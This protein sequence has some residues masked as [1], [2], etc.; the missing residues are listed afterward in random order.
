MNLHH[1]KLPGIIVMG[2][3]V[4]ALGIIRILGQL[5]IPAIIMDDTPWNISRFS[6]FCSKF[7]FC[8]KENWSTQFEQW[9]QQ[10]EYAHWVVFPTHD[11]HV[12]FL[13]QNKNWLSQHFTVST[14]DWERVS[15]F[16]DKTKS[17]EMCK[18]LNIPMATTYCH[19]EP[20]DLDE[21]KITFPCIIKPSVM[22]QFYSQLKKK[23][24][25]CRNREELKAQYQLASSIIPKEEIIIQ[26][27]IQGDSASQFSVGVLAVNGEIM[28]Q[29]S[30]CRMRQHPIDFGNATTYAE[31]MVVPEI[32][33]YAKQI[34]AHTRFTGMCEIEFKK[35]QLDGEYK[36]LEVNPR[37]WKW[38]AIAVKAEVPF[39]EMF[40]QYLTGNKI[41]PQLEF[42]KA[43]FFHS[44]TDWP[45]R[46]KL[47][48]MG[49]DYAFQKVAPC[50]DAVWSA[51]DPMPWMIEKLLL[52]YLLLKR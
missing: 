51:E 29:L 12:E 19:V 44:L 37:T 49:K 10:N 21:I 24:L 8:T 25:V 13:S 39:L 30:A 17:Y 40:Y 33:E 20:Q 6:K 28:A 9:M 32:I 5:K 26:S 27:I 11:S 1:S 45:I 50:Q 23:V 36:F 18:V 3:H 48:R 4:Q 16:Y 52:P 15:V 41:T 14:D 34:M 38:H 2:G 7:I 31:T 35:D 42:K 43:G 46:L 22:H 47:W